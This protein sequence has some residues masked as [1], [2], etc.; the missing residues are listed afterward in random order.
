MNDRLTEP[1]APD[2]DNP[3]PL[4]PLAGNWH[5]DDAEAY[6]DDFIH[7]DHRP[8]EE[9]T[10]VP[11]VKDEL[12]ITTR[13]VTRTETVGTVNGVATDP[14]QILPADPN[15]KSVTIAFR[16]SATTNLLIGPE[17]SQMYSQHLALTLYAPNSAVAIP[18]VLDGHTGPVWVHCIDPA[19]SV[20]VSVVAVTS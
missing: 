7:A 12:P 15:R 10:G 11:H 5:D 20:M 18:I 1:I 13:L 6:E 4:G 17:K 2:V 3:A 19:N 14:I 9:V 16:G 8:P